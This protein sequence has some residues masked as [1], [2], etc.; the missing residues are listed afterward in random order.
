MKLKKK[1]LPFF[2]TAF[3]ILLICK[4]YDIGSISLEDVY[5]LKIHSHERPVLYK[6]NNILFYYGRAEPSESASGNR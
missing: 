2:F 1:I 3:L 5:F 6:L 4:E